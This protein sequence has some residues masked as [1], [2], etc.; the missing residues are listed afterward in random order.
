MLDRMIRSSP[1]FIMSEGCEIMCSR[2]YALRRAF[3]DVQ[4]QADWKQPKGQNAA[5]WRSKVRWDLANE[6]DWRSQLDGDEML[7]N[8]EKDLQERLHVKTFFNKYF[9]K[10]TDPVAPN[11]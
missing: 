8:V 2:I 1:E 10:A 6:V 9:H 7:P 3:H 11:V 4:Q 5:K